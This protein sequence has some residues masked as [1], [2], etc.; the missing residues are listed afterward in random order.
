VQSPALLILGEVARLADALHWFG[1]APLAPV[2]TAQHFDNLRA[3]KL[4]QA[5]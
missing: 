1:S 5:A 2:P 4:P 3:P